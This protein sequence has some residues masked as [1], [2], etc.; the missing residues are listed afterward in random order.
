MTLDRGHLIRFTTAVVSSRE[1]Q[2]TTERQLVPASVATSQ[3]HLLKEKNS[4]EW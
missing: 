1:V 3:L 4:G 2:F